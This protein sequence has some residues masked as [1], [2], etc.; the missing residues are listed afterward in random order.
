MTFGLKHGVAALA[1]LAMA[2]LANAGVTT[3]NNTP[4][5]PIEASLASWSSS[6]YGEIFRAP[7]SN[8]TLESFSFYIEGTVP[9]L[10]AGV[11]QWNG[12]AAGPAL[13]T[14]TQF[15]G[16]DSSYTEVTVNTGGL[17]LVA[18]QDYVMYFSANGIAAD[19]STGMESFELGT[20]SPLN[21]DLGWDSG[22]PNNGTAWTGR[23]QGGGCGSSSAPNFAYA[24]TFNN[25]AATSVP[26]PAPLALV[27][28][29]LVAAAFARRK[30]A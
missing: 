3:Y 20:G 27:G 8:D 15:S 23:C 10:Y 18:N 21:V 25:P 17:N 29:G 9:E 2:G 4:S 12:T 26:E 14:S 1:L 5:G 6:T 16:I 11:A 22:N 28:I 30:R 24:M 13:F 19:A 7:A